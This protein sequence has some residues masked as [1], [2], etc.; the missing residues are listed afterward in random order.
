MAKELRTFKEESKGNW[1]SLAKHDDGTQRTSD[2]QLAIG[3]LQ[4][5]ADSLENIDSTLRTLSFVSK[6]TEEKLKKEKRKH[7]KTK[8]DLRAANTKLYNAETKLKNL[9]AKQ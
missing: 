1:R 7:T 9:G 8:A 4:R 2:M 6:D 3:C 5:I